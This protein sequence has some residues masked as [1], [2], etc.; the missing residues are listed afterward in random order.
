MIFGLAT[1]R[2]QKPSK[3]N[4]LDKTQ[5]PFLSVEKTANQKKAGLK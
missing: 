2:D 5:K 4:E 3:T 1:F